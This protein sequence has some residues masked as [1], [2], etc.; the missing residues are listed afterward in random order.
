VEFRLSTQL[1]D[2][3]PSVEQDESRDK[4]AIAIYIKTMR[5]G[6]EK[7][8]EALKNRA[9]GEPPVS[10]C[11][12]KLLSGVMDTQLIASPIPCEEYLLESGLRISQG[13]LFEL[14]NPTK[15]VFSG[16]ARFRWFSAIKLVKD[17]LEPLTSDGLVKVSCASVHDFFVPPRVCSV[18]LT[19][20]YCEGTPEL[21]KK[22]AELLLG[23]C[24]NDNSESLISIMV[25]L[26]KGGKNFK[27]LEHKEL[28]V[29]RKLCRLWTAFCDLVNS[30]L[31][32]MADVNVVHLDIRSNSKFT[33]NILVYENGNDKIELRLIDFDSVVL[34]IEASS[35]G[36]ESQGDVIWSKGLVTK[37][38]VRDLPAHLYLFWQVLWIA[39]R[40]HTPSKQQE[41]VKANDFVS[42][43]FVD[44]K[45]VDFKAWLGDADTVSLKAMNHINITSENIKEALRI[46][47]EIF[48]KKTLEMLSATNQCWRV[49]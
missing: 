13:E 11:C 44:G 42:F 46:L 34:S 16:P 41:K 33:Y 37:H 21:K 49:E 25:D 7:A 18:A 20:L 40:W 45:F 8:L 39:Y 19:D 30:L 35:I 5:F 27:I 43:L 24:Y 38:G 2:L 4:R 15:N 47:K 23:Y 1:I 28:C 6:L 17:P 3:F 10:L 48:G 22:I 14:R 31:L 36:E 9:E 29:P 32:P 26:R 12:R